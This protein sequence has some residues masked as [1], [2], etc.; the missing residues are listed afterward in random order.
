MDTKPILGASLAVLAMAVAGCTAQLTA[1]Q[2]A[3][4]TIAIQGA[5][6]VVTVSASDQ[7][8]QKVEVTNPGNTDTLN[9][10]VQVNQVSG[11]CKVHVIVQVKETGEQLASQDIE[12]GGSAGSSGSTSGSGNGTTTVTQTQTQTA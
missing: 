9:V 4:F 6:Q 10:K 2:T 3:P 1:Q 12:V 8:P 11:P 5:P 7:A